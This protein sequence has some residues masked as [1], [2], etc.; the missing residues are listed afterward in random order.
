MNGG[1]NLYYKEWHVK[2]IK[3]VIDLL[4]GDENIYQFDELKEN[5]SIHGTF[6]DYQSILESCLL[7]EKTKINQNSFVCKNIKQ[8]IARNCYLKLLCNITKTCLFKYTE[9]FTTKK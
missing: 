1:Q 7:T 4:N 6:S 3:N 2:S 8:Y 9:N 5:Y